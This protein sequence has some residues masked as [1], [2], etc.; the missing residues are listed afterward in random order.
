[1]I[2]Q[3]FFGVS[4]KPWETQD[5]DFARIDVEPAGDDQVLAATADGEIAV[6]AQRALVAGAKVAVGRERLRRLVGQ[7]PVA[8]KVQ[9][10]PTAQLGRSLAPERVR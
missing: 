9:S 3:R 8:R 1:M 7:L 4:G 2:R 5:L 10:A 6:L